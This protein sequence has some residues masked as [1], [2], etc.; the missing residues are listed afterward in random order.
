M[1]DWPITQ[2]VGCSRVGRGGGKE[3]QN[4]LSERTACFVR[5]M[6]LKLGVLD[7]DIDSTP[8]GQAKLLEIWLT[9]TQSIVLL[10]VVYTISHDQKRQRAPQLSVQL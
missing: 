6:Q 9:E 3:S 1:S 8:P 4:S 2:E 5:P 7:P 10:S